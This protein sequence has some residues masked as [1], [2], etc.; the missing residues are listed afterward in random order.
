MAQALV[1]L[2]VDATVGDMTSLE[3]IAKQLLQSNCISE[4]V[5]KGF[6]V[7]ALSSEAVRRERGTSKEV[8]TVHRE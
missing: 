2:A 4:S 5:L 7:M 1:M 6:L 3:E 8:I